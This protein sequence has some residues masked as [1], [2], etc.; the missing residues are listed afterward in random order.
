MRL[1][2]LSYRE[3]SATELRPLLYRSQKAAAQKRQ[4][5][6]TEE[7]RYVSW[8]GKS[9]KNPEKAEKVQIQKNRS[10]KTRRAAIIPK[11]RS[12][13]VRQSCWS[14]N[15]K[16]LNPRSWRAGKIVE[17]AVWR[18]KKV[19]KRRCEKRYPKKIERA[20]RSLSV[21]NRNSKAGFHSERN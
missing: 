3:I 19:G 13:N 8:W 16:T 4:K 14:P 11:K 1:A 17:Q 15:I 6:T 18:T 12:Q 10:V 2:H 9:M 21:T 20:G 7:K 5:L